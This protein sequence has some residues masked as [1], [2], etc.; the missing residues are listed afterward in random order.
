MVPNEKNLLS[1]AALDG[2]GARSPERSERVHVIG[3]RFDVQVC[4]RHHG[5]AVRDVDEAERVTYLVGDHDCQGVVGEFVVDQDLPR[6][7]VV[8]PVRRG[9]G[10]PEVD[11]QD[12]DVGGGQSAHLEGR[13][14]GPV[15]EI[16]GRVDALH[17]HRGGTF[18]DQEVEGTAGVEADS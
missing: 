2:S 7:G 16:D 5:R 6:L 8:E 18:V 10:G 12:G 11:R 15:P 9:G 14:R 4:R 1:L 3:V 13:E 17:L